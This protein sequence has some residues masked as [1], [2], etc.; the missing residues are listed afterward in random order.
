MWVTF[1]L[2]HFS[3]L[4]AGHLTQA[5][6]QSLCTVFTAEAPN[7]IKDAA[8]LQGLSPDLQYTVLCSVGHLCV[9]AVLS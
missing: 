8:A 5:I 7:L 9:Q 6:A 3:E 2:P 4:F 1:L